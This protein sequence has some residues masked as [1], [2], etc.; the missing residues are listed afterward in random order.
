M[1]RLLDEFQSLDIED[2]VNEERDP[3]ENLHVERRVQIN[4]NQ[5]FGHS[6]R[7]TF[8][9]MSPENLKEESPQKK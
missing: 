1:V 6:S 9:V 8:N 4:S 2:D 7:S 3:V 5:V